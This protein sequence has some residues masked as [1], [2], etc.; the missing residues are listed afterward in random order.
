VLNESVELCPLYTA[1]VITG[2]KIGPSPQWLVQRLESVGL[3]PIN[4]VVDITNFVLL[5]CGQPMHAF[6]IAK[7]HERRIVV[8]RAKDGEQITAIDGSKHTLNSRMLMIADAHKPV[9]VAGVMGGLDSEVDENTTDILLESAIFDP[10]SVRSTSRILKLSSDSS[11]RFER[12]V[13]PLGVDTASRR[14]AQLIAEIA[15]GSLA[16]GVIRVGGPDPEPRMVDLHIERCNAL[17]GVDLN[18][19]QQAD[20]LDRLGLHPVISV[21]KITCTIPTFR[22]DLVREVDL[23]EEVARSYGLN[24]IGLQDKIHIVTRPPQ[25]DIIAGQVA[26]DVLVSHGYHETITFSFIRPQYGQPFLPEGAQAV[27]IEDDRRKAEPML[28]PSLVPSLLICRKSNQDYGNTGISLFEN[29]ATWIKYDE[30]IEER[31][32]LAMLRDVDDGETSL[33]NL[34]GSIEEL[35]Q[36]L[37]G[38][39]AASSLRVESVEMKN[40]QVAARVCI[41]DQVIGYFGLLNDTLR[42]LFDLQTPVVVAELALE[43]LLALYPTKR[44]TRSLPRFPGIERDLSVVVDESVS[45]QQIALQVNEMR[46]ELMELLEFIGTYRGKQ[47]PKGKKSVS[48][49]MRFR[50]PGRTLRHEQVDPQVAVV[51]DRLKQQ[52]GAELRE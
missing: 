28:R 42:D 33:R 35:V 9:A 43:L 48:F 1:R 32:N 24:K 39:P 19:Q 30:R 14:A 5:E 18:A 46:P 13:D 29:A 52:L 17:L 26:A 38:D 16:K 22:L 45:W 49:R 20:Y 27:M 36:R 37:G 7:L 50:D 44:V 51:S 25:H 11:F 23:V 31:L 47:I 4:N 8:R 10:L 21:G 34:R 41:N 40:Y 12:G 15:G 2:V 6:D 3:R